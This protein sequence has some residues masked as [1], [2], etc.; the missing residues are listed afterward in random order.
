MRPAK[1]IQLRSRIFNRKTEGVHD[2]RENGTTTLHGRY[3]PQ[4][5]EFCN[6]EI[7]AVAY[8]SMARLNDTKRIYHAR[9]SLSL[10]K[11]FMRWSE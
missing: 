4:D 8:A 7:S 2:H 11:R 1:E 3:Y 6:I 10:N 5:N 9:L